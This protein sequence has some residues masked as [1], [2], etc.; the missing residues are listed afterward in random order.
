[1][2][3]K[4]GLPV[5][6]HVSWASGNGPVGT[7]PISYFN[8]ATDWPPSSPGQRSA[9]CLHGPLPPPI[10][11][12]PEANPGALATE[13]FRL[14]SP[15][16]RLRVRA[17]SEGRRERGSGGGAERSRSHFGGRETIGRKRRGTGLWPQ[18]T[19]APPGP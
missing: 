5:H 2:Q 10:P 18:V 3:G 12:A 11:E 4:P 9:P 13:S 17:N 19:P 14:P 8:Y 1:M 16:A 6:L 7:Q 15:L